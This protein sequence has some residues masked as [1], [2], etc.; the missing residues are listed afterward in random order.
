[1]KRG[2]RFYVLLPARGTLVRHIMKGVV[3]FYVFLPNAERFFFSHFLFTWPIHL[4]I[5]YE[6]IK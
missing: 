4:P 3:R 5:R 1:M 2:V 6:S